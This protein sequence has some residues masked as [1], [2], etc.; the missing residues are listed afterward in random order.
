VQLT[1]LLGIAGRVPS[2]SSWRRGVGSRESAYLDD[3]EDD[4]GAKSDYGS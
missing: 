4:D 2:V 1:K 3:G